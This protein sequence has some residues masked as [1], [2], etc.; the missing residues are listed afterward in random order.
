MSEPT[1]LT[2]VSTQQPQSAHKSA[3]RHNAPKSVF[4]DRR[5]LDAILNIYGRRV[6]AGDWRDY[7]MSGLKDCAVFSVYRRASEMPLY[8]IEKRPKLRNK[9]GA[10]SVISASGMILK[11]GHELKQV[12]KVLE[13]KQLSL[14][15]DI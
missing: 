11:R 14:V 6:A 10:Y 4:W 15:T 1:H 2:V 9:Q 12:L 3:R 13:P 8:R 7:A 5:E